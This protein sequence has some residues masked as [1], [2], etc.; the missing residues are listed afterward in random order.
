MQ[1]D[2]QDDEEVVEEEESPPPPSN[3]YL[4]EDQGWTDCT[5]DCGGGDLLVQINVLFID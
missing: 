3:D 4:W 2:R 1:R 5:R